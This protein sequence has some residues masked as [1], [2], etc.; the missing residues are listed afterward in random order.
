MPFNFNLPQLF[1]SKTEA[2]LSL[3]VPD[4]MATAID[5]LGEVLGL[6]DRSKTIRW[7]LDQ[8]LGEAIEQG[9]IPAPKRIAG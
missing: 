2:K 3:K 5:Q 1:R 7:C 4:D 9:K 8:V 6:N